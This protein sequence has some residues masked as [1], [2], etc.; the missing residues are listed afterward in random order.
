ML[1]PRSTLC[2]GAASL[3]PSP[4]DL[5]IAGEGVI[6]LPPAGVNP[7][8]STHSPSRNHPSLP[9]RIGQAGLDG[10][11]RIPSRHV[12]TCRGSGAQGL[13]S[14]D[15]ASSGRH[16][17]A[18]DSALHPAVRKG[19]GPRPATP[20]FLPLLISSFFLHP[21]AFFRHPVQYIHRRTAPT[22]PLHLAVRRGRGAHPS[23]PSLSGP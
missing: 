20:L 22:S 15:P 10:D 1:A 21:S 17:T 16:R 5:L 19:R 2:F 14:L 8:G 4:A 9:D 23:L 12:V 18:E 7:A 11:I 6:P 3:R 13:P